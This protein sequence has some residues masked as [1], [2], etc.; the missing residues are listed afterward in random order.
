MKRLEHLLLFF[1]IIAFMPL[2]QAQQP[3]EGGIYGGMVTYQGDLAESQYAELKELNFALGAFLRYHPHN[4]YKVKGNVIYSRISGSDANAK[5]KKK[6]LQSR[7]WSFS[8]HIVE[9]TITGEYHPWG[10]S[11][12]DKIGMF[13]KQISPY[14]GL[15]I[16][17]ANFDPQIVTT[18]PEDEDRFPELDAK[19][20]S[21]SFPVTMGVRIDFDKHF[22]AGFEGGWRMTLNDYLD[23]V[24]ENGNPNKNDPYIFVGAS[25]SYFFGYIESFNF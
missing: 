22:T 23:G 6:Y 9:V 20:T 14:V 8:S 5:T 1:F 19:T 15:G 18:K 13:Q 16:G 21:V 7:G 25:I 2:L 24:S 4:K 17:V 3:L 10:K 12:E 11:R